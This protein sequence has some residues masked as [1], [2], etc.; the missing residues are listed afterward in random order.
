[1]SSLF[2]RILRA[3]VEGT[4]A[5]TPGGLE[6]QAF[7]VALEADGLVP[8][9][10]I[11]VWQQGQQRALCRA[12]PAGSEGH[13][14]LAQIPAGILQPGAFTLQA[15]GCRTAQLEHAAPQDWTKTYLELEVVATPANLQ[16]PAV[17]AAG[18]GGIKVYFGIHKHMH[19]PYYRAAEDRY[20]D[21]SMDE[22]FETRHGAYSD[23]LLDAIERY[24]GGGLAHAG[25]STSYSGSLIEQLHRCAREGLGRGGFGGWPARLAGASTYRTALGNPRLDFA[26]FGFFHPLMPLIPARDIIRQIQWHRRII[27]D[28]F[29]VEAS[30]LLFPP[31]T[32]FHARMIPALCQAGVTGVIYD[33]IHRFRTCKNYP[34]AG[35]PEG[36]LPPNLSEQENPP[37]NDWLQLK[38]IWAGSLISPSLLRPSLL[39]YVDP[40]GTE[41]RIV[42]IPA[43]RYIGN[44]DARGGYGAL[45]YPSV[46]G[47]LYDRI[48]ATGSFDPQHPPFFLLHSDGDNYGGG[49][50]SYYR[51]NTEGLVEWLKQDQRFELTTMLDYLA[52]FPVDETRAEHV[53]PGAW[54]GADNGDPQFMK[55]FSRWDQ[56]YSPDL[57]SWAVLTALQN[58]LHSL[59]DMGESSPEFDRAERLLLMAETSC[60]WYWTGQDVWDAQVTEAANLAHSLLCSKLEMLRQGDRSGPTI[61]PPW[62]HPT[63]PGGKAWG[64]GGLVDAPRQGT[65]DTLIAD[66]S[67]IQSAEVIVRSDSGEQRIRLVDFGAYPSRT[68][69]KTTA[70]HFAALLP[71]GLGDVRYYVEA[72]DQKGNL[73]RGSLE[74]TYLP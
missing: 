23:Y 47:Q 53:E 64:Q 61:F 67:G 42:G 27:R 74:R 56:D 59:E 63:N 20:W 68:G 48:V 57:N 72:V 9:A 15:E 29:G 19:Q 50:D 54:S 25:I 4:L 2:T 32:A 70:H 35:P 13:R 62:T 69:A 22:I 11:I 5:T 41:H 18:E 66:I 21:G 45:Q 28:T 46:L 73:S 34:Y 30:P 17:V 8:F 49:A 44:E 12:E 43:E 60:Y 14:Y 39:K 10:Q 65:V 26:S 52:R 7:A 71:I 40:D 6:S 1:M 33:S 36:M 38:N 3:E 55:W 58:L 51:H 37:V 24:V 31:E 16:S